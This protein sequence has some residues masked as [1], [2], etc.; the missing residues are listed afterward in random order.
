M[1][2]DAIAWVNRRGS[3]STLVRALREALPGDSRFGDPMSTAGTEPAQ[4]LARRAWGATS[5]RFST[6]A[7]LGLAALQLADWLGPDGARVGGDGELAILFTDLVGFS[8]WA[9]HAGDDDSLQL[10]RDVDAQV[11]EAVGAEGGAI[12]KR[13]GDGTMAVFD[14]GDAALRAAVTALRRAPDT[15]VDGYQP[16]MRAGLHSGTP[17][18]IGN[19]FI[20]VDV[21]IA[22]RL[23]EAANPGELLM[24]GEIVDGLGE[25]AGH[26]R[27]L[28][29]RPLPGVPPEVALFGL[30]A[31]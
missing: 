1:I 2:R 5:G 4:L 13:L 21:N 22:A 6:L 27:P 28:G 16:Q 20:G 3:L 9:V 7:E 23:C 24:S 15:R 12:V 31:R 10:L 18:P 25:N 8:S 14:D 29:R 26:V 11:T 19:D 30:M 17:Q